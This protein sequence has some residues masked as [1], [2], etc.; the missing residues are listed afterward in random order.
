[1]DYEIWMMKNAFPC[2]SPVFSMYSLCIYLI[3]PLYFSKTR[4]EG[5]PG[6]W[7][8][9]AGGTT[10]QERGLGRR[11]HISGERKRVEG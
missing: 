10:R 4:K 1:M 2:I 3:F 7:K 6:K 11:E 8:D 9:Y 5:G